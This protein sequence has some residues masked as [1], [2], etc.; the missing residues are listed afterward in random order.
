[1]SSCKADLLSASSL[2][3]SA[4][5]IFL[6]L[7]TILGIGLYAISQSYSVNTHSTRR[8]AAARRPFFLEEDV[9]VQLAFAKFDP[10]PANSSQPHTNRFN[11]ALLAHVQLC[12]PSSQTTSPGRRIDSTFSFSHE[13]ASSWLECWKFESTAC[14]WMVALLEEDLAHILR[15]PRV[16][17]IGSELRDEP[18][19]D[20]HTAADEF[21]WAITGVGLFRK[22][23]KFRVCC[24]VDIDVQ[25]V[26]TSHFQCVKT[27]FGVSCKK[28]LS[29]VQV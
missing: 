9:D 16:R 14:A 10:G 19:P 11:G 21:G 24:A 20:K 13:Y 23:D 26:L 18:F 27:G 3:L 8:S 17:C 15:R 28:G 12:S 5:G 22:T 29:R 7:F 6:S 1:L 25:Q 4:L 2:L